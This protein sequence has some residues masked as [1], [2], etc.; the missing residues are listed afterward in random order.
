[1]SS[2]SKQ[3]LDHSSPQPGSPAS[4]SPGPRRCSLELPHS[5]RPELARA[6]LAR[7]R[8]LSESRLPART[9][10]VLHRFRGGHR[11]LS[12]C[13]GP[14][15]S[16][17]PAPQLPSASA[18]PPRPCTAGAM[19]PLRSHKPTVAVRALL[20]R[21]RPQLTKQ[22]PPGSGSPD[23]RPQRCLFLFLPAPTWRSSCSPLPRIFPAQKPSF[24]RFPAEPGCLY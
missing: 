6:P 4:P 1:V 11:T 20:A 22:R 2:A 14:M 8:R 16:P 21:P 9:R 3:E 12:L 18:L 23:L 7:A 13:P 15:P 10:A 5:V 19:P 24:F 17:G